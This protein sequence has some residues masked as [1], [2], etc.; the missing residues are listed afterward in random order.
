M[1]KFILF[2]VIS[3]QLTGLKSQSLGTIGYLDIKNGF[4]EFKIG[5]PKSKWIS[6]MKQFPSSFDG[7]E[8]FVYSGDC[9][10]NSF[11][12]T[13]KDIIL[14]FKEN[15]LVGINVT[16]VHF[17]KG[18]QETWKAIDID[19]GIQNY[20][21]IQ[22]S[23]KLLFSEQTSEVANKAKAGEPFLSSQWIANNTVLS[24]NYIFEGTFV[25]D[26]ANFNIV[27]KKFIEARVDSDF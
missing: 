13:I 26:Y 25:G 16:F 27:S 4:Q 19:V 20:R 24:L 22:N 8:S 14:T 17:Q 15:L 18:S 10:T 7:V 6:Q 2:L 5:D 9:C 12:F 1:K 21:S 3:V 11:G 23:L